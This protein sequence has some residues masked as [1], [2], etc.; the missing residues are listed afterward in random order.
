MTRTQTHPPI[1]PSLRPS[2]PASPA[3][4]IPAPTPPGTDAVDATKRSLDAAVNHLLGLQAP[5]GYWCAELEGDSILQSEYILFKWIIGQENDPRIPWIANYLRTQQAPSGG[6]VQYPGAAICV[7]S[8]AKAYFALKLCGDDINAPHMKKMREV[9]LAGG[10]AEKCNSFSKFYLAALGQIRYDAVPSIPPEIIF[11]P[12]WFYFHLDKVSAWTRTMIT[13]LSIVVSHKPCRT[14]T[15]EQ[16]I[17]ELYVNPKI[18]HKLIPGDGKHRTWSRIFLSLDRVLKL[19]DA[20]GLTPLRNRAL[21]RIENWIVEHSERSD[22]LGAIFPP[23]VYI[24]IALRL[25]GYKDDHPIIVK[26]HKDLEDLM[27]IDHAKQQIRIQPC[28][29]PIWD[30]GIAAYALTEAGLHKESEQMARCA[31]WLLS[32]ECRQPGDWVNNARYPIEPSGWFF[33]HNNGFYPDVDDTAMVAMAL[34]KIGGDDA[35]AA[36]K[37]G[38]EFCLTLQND[39]GGWAAFDRT[40]ER[41]ILE[42]VPFADHNAIQDP[43]C[44]DIA[45]RVL[46]SLGYHGYTVADKFVADAVKFIRTRQDADGAWFGR[47]GVNYVYGTWEVLCGL[48]NVGQDMNA[49]WIQKAGKWLRS[50]QMPDGSFG[51]SCAS[52]DDLSFKGKGESTAS[53]TAWGTMGLMAIYG[54]SDPDVLRGIKWLRD[55]QLADGNWLEL[56]FTGTGFPKVFYLRYHYY[57]LYF[58]VMCLGR[59]YHRIKGT[60]AH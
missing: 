18:R 28:V 23:M 12:K 52:Y 8:T 4:H 21:K 43:S 48:R 9:I 53:Q 29:S 11:L 46:E 44:P 27:I 50:V 41:P 59:W 22:G 25:R 57:K 6:F 60:D 49:D 39:D 32:K 2:A 1:K 47:W 16:S 14:L 20:T 24:L 30:T 26:G 35:V 54:P 15:P 33:E 31:K 55:T 7:S 45:G 5:E 3:P 58:P 10:G 19:I 40:V 36:S 13:P 17:N 42:H 37:R 34:K 38:I 56:N 51:E